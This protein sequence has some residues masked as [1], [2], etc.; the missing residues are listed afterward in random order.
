MAIAGI[1]M[2]AWFEIA[3]LYVLGHRRNAQSR[4]SQG[5]PII[6]PVGVQPANSSTHSVC[7]DMTRTD[8]GRASLATKH[9][10]D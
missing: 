1:F 10:E 7:N 2:I 9:L 3:F 4:E 8:T 6:L 5:Q